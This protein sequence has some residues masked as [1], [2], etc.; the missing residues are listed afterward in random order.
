MAGIASNQKGYRL[1]WQI[2]SLPGLHLRR[3]ND[4]FYRHKKGEDI[5]IQCFEYT[6]EEYGY[7][8]RMVGNKTSNNILIPEHKNT[9]YFLLVKGGLEENSWVKLLADM[10]KLT[11]A[12]TVY[13]IDL[14]KPKFNRTK[15]IATIGPATSSYKMLKEIIVAGV[16]V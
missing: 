16:D 14:N 7:T 11:F 15:I 4:L 5:Y 1:V 12:L 8:Y 13:A 3:I 10:K 9:D 2:N 6:D